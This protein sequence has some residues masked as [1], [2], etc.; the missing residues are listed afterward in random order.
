M[1]PGWLKKGLDSAK[2]EYEIRPIM[3]EVEPKT[4]SLPQEKLDKLNI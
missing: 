1:K 2:R 3:D 4:I